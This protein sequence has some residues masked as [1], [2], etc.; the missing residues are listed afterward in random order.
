MF[1]VT[2]EDQIGSSRLV[3]LQKVI[4]LTFM[5]DTD[6]ISSKIF[7]FLTIFLLTDWEDLL[8]IDKLN[9]DPSTQ[10][11]F[12]KINMLL[13]TYAPLKRIY[14]CNWNLKPKPWITLGLKN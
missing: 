6:E 2:L 4:N 3:P 11:Y 7:L 1:F 9:V 8:K 13:D 12:N 5:K 14:E 10:M